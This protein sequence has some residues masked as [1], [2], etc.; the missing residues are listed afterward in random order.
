M[1]MASSGAWTY[2]DRTS[3][4]TSLSKTLKKITG[5]PVHDQSQLNF[6][7]STPDRSE[8]NKKAS[9]I[10]LNIH[11]IFQKIDRLAKL[12]KRSSIFDDPS[13]EIQELT[14]LIK[15]DIR[16]LNV[17]VSDLQALQDTAVADGS[18]SKDTVV[19]CTAICDDLKTRLMTATKSFQDALTIRTKN[20]KAHEDRRQIFSTNLARENPLKQP[21]KTTAEPPPW[22]TPSSVSPA[23]D[24]QG[25]SQL[26]RR[27]ASDNPPSHQM[28][29]SSMLQEVVPR[30]E[31]FTQN[32]ATALQNV[33]STISELSGIFTH[34]ATMVAQQGELAIRIDDNI[35][36]SLTNVEGAQGALLKYLNQLSSNRSL[37]VKI[38]LIVIL[39]LCIFIFFLA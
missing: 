31:S 8:F 25:S 32:R 29:T 26:R 6:A 35:D 24:V 7:L 9:K 17:G 13:K 23:N 16:T 36:E 3:E 4:F 38:F 27:L 30:Q 1:S 5:S 19:H 28:E 22:S 2:R 10:G 21:P 33:E 18:H 15:K 34:L 11:Q 39:F 14:S 20:M 37:M 12:A